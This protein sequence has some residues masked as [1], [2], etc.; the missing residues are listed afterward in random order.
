MKHSIF[1]GLSVIVKGKI[2]VYQNVTPES[3]LNFAA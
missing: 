3:F 1:V 2:P